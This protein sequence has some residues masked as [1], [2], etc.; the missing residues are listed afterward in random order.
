M[1][2]KITRLD[3]ENL[4]LNGTNKENSHGIPVIKRF[5][6]MV[7]LGSPAEALHQCSFQICVTRTCQ[8]YGNF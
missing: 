1:A 8:N 4:G 6:S 5:I 7:L 3:N 2:V